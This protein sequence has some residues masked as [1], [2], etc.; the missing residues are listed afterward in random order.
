MEREEETY[1]IIG[2]AME[3][4]Q[5][6]GKGFLEKVYQ[7]A[8]EV[9]LSLREVPYRAQVRLPI[10]YKGRLLEQFY[11]PDLLVFGDIPIELKAHAEPFSKADLK[12]IVNALKVTPAATG[13]IF[14]FGRDS[15]DY[16]RVFP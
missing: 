9:E 15:L 3:V 4:H 10:Q 7:E 11:V 2:A 16:R 8:M 6:L 12:Q 5:Q 1:T 13:L 14:N